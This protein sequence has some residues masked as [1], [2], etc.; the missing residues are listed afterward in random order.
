MTLVVLV[1]DEDISSLPS[2]WGRLILES[3]TAETGSSHEFRRLLSPQPPNTKNT[4]CKVR[5]P[6]KATVVFRTE[7]SYKQKLK[8]TP[9]KIKV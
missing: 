1:S 9:K 6:S 5:L 4:P 8:L 2:S 7:P 3:W